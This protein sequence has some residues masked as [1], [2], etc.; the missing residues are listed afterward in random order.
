MIGIASRIRQRSF[1]AL[2]VASA[3]GAVMP[4]AFAPFGWFWVAPLALGMLFWLW[5]EANPREAFW[6]GCCFGWG[7]FL[8][9]TYWV[10]I[11]VH[12][13]GQAPV[14][15]AI[16]LTIGLVFLMGLYSGAVGYVGRRW[17][18]TR[19]VVQQVL[20]W[21]SLWLVAEWIR[22]WFLS[23]FGW[24][25]LGY[26]QSDS[27]LIGYAP[28]GGVL[29]MG[30]AVTLSAGAI[31]LALASRVYWPM[32]LAAGV[33][34]GG[35]AL[36]TISWTESRGSVVSVSL[37]QGAVPQ[38]L[39]WLPQ[40]RLPTL[41]L[42]R[43]LT[44]TELGRDLIIWPEAAIPVLYHQVQ[45]YLD[46][47]EETALA[48][49][50]TVVLGILKDDP[51][52]TFENS[53]IALNKTRSTYVKRH[54]VPFGEYFPVP[55]FIRRWMRLMSLPYTDA[56]PGDDGQPPI[57]AGAERLGVTICYEDVFGSEQLKLARESTLLVNVSN[58]AWFGDSLAPHQHLQIA[59]LRAAEAGRYLLRST[60]TGISAIID[61]R[62]EVVS[63]S[64][65]FRTHVLRGTV[66]GFE[67][68]T[69]YARVGDW[70]VG[71]SGPWGVVRGPPVSDYLTT[72]LTIRPGT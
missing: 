19:P 33:W 71:G 10:Y 66:T 49:G 34:L 55:A 70:P 72:K 25:S 56:E 12:E 28:L 53:V 27:W 15:L 65:Q 57:E 48:A 32:A 8:T 46:A 41:Q 39:K 3:A 44:S 31:N 1:I 67:G 45:G 54:L 42:Y 64:P 18:S 21:P 36:S 16:F 68:A 17:L 7:M 9:G 2:L 40:Q 50:S 22:G 29:L 63:R 43:D 37:V 6:R 35:Y 14:L 60:N 38:D 11:S 5:T 13:F 62:G 51:D 23:G 26:S 20:V 24:L 4:L 47:V 61:P 58:D 52:S 59:R 69:P 30:V